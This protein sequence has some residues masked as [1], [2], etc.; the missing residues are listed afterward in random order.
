[1]IVTDELYGEIRSALDFEA[2]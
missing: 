2:N 1:M